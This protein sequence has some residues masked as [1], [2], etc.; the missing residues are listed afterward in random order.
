MFTQ[1]CSRIHYVLSVFQHSQSS[2]FINAAK[3]QLREYRYIHVIWNVF[4][5]KR[6]SSASHNQEKVDPIHGRIDWNV[7][8]MRIISAA[9][10]IYWSGVKLPY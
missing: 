9:D 8:S 2:P 6:Q 10:L 7:D 3:P 5:R 4:S 1:A